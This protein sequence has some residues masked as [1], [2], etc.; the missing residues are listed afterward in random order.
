MCWT[1][2]YVYYCK[3]SHFDLDLVP[4]IHIWVKWTLVRVPIFHIF[5]KKFPIFLVW[6]LTTPPALGVEN[7]KIRENSEINRGILQGV[8]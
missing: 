3:A 8:P 4:G 7:V 1:Y 5:H 2:A 6:D